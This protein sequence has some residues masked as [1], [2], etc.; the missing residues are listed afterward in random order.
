MGIWQ[1]IKGIFSDAEPEAGNIPVGQSPAP[2]DGGR[3]E[4][5][6]QA[7]RAQA[8]AAPLP[9]ERAPMDP[10]PMAAGFIPAASPIDDALAFEVARARSRLGMGESAYMTPAMLD[11]I[12]RQ[13]IEAERKKIVSAD[14]ATSAA[15]PMAPSAPRPAPPQSPRPMGSPARMPAGARAMAPTQPAGSYGRRDDEDSLMF[16]MMFPEAGV[17]RNPTSMK[18]WAV[19]MLTRDHGDNHY[20]GAGFH[21]QVTGSGPNPQIRIESDDGRVVQGTCDM[22]MGRLELSTD[23]GQRAAFDFGD[24]AAADIAFD[25]GSGRGFDWSQDTGLRASNYDSDG[26]TAWS[27]GALDSSALDAGARPGIWDAPP[28]QSPAPFFDAGARQDSWGSVPAA[29]PE[30]P[31]ADGPAFDAGHGGSN[32]NA[33]AP[34]PE[35]ASDRLSTAY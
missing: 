3:R 8:G 28:G 30:I 27:S 6:R 12:E 32:W 22:S 1:K 13:R 24:A 25:S 20:Q 33:P 2:D 23:E 5:I 11:R 35:I 4:R 21:A 14:R 7:M 26:K 16:M 19:W 9:T 18:A 10:A 17:W 15:A 29:A 31:P 34:A